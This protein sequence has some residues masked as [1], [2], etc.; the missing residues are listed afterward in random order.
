MTAQAQDPK[1]TR[2]DLVLD[3]IAGSG[4]LTAWGV[5]AVFWSQLPDRV[6]MHFDLTGQPDAWGGR[7]AAL[8][9]PVGATVVMVV[10][11]LVGLRLNDSDRAG[12][13]SRQRLATPRVLASVRA[14][15]ACV[16]ALI[17]FQQCRVALG[18]IQGLGT[19]TVLL[20]LALLLVPIA[21]GLAGVRRTTAHG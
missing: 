4:L 6:P 19:W 11:A 8:I 5:A 13:S 12:P 15:L 17:T 2:V 9:G 3:A 20:V 1:L 7:S 14:A 16:T 18:D 10:L 21:I